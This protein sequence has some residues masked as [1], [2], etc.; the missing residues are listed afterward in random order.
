MPEDPNEHVAQMFHGLVS[1]LQHGDVAAF[2]ERQRLEKM[3]RALLRQGQPD[4]GL[5]AGELLKKMDGD[6]Q[7]EQRRIE[8]ELT[9]IGREAQAA[10]DQKSK[11]DEPLPEGSFPPPP[12]TA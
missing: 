3:Q 10:V 6:P 12:T 4:Q 8:D 2:E 5:S 7:D 11:Q 1:D 9:R